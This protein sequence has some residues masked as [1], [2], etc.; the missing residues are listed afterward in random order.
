MAGL[1]NAIDEWLDLSAEFLCKPLLVLIRAI[2]RGL[3]L[4][5][6][7]LPTGGANKLGK[8]QLKPCRHPRMS[9]LSLQPRLKSHL[10]A[11]DT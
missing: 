2:D 11:L 7:L 8:R 5:G 3:I 9:D 6:G 1:F 4:I 10:V